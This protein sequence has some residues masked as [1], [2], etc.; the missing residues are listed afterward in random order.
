[1]FGQLV[2]EDTDTPQRLRSAIGRRTALANKYLKERLAPMIGTVPF[3]TH[4]ARHSV[5]THLA[6]SGAANLA[7][8]GYL[9]H[10]NLRMLDTYLAELRED[11]LWDE[12]GGVLN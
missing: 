1:M 12:L 6:K 3:T 9:G 4:V 10:R 5:A 7:I 8:K 11:E 2:P